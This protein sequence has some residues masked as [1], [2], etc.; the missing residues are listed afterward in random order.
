MKYYIITGTGKGI[1]KALA[2]E[3]LQENDATVIG[4]SRHQ[5]ITHPQY[6]HHNVDLSQTEVLIKKLPEIF[7][8]MND[9][10]EVVLVN[11]A[12]VL[13]EIGYVGEKQNEDFAYVFSVNVTAPA[14]LMN[15]F[16]QKYA[17]LKVPKIILNISCL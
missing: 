13:G 2:E 1:G 5:T 3:L 15:A 8:E 7:Q 14:I 9:A 10:E 12:G 4:I 11:N 17:A 6:Q 16:L